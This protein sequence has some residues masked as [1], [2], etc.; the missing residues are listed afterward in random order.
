[1]AMALERLVP[2][3]I[4]ITLSLQRPRTPHCETIFMLLGSPARTQIDPSGLPSQ[5]L[6][7][8]HRTRSIPTTAP[9]DD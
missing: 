6:H 9:F 3:G 8:H 7:A 2:N 1:M 5:K 4:V